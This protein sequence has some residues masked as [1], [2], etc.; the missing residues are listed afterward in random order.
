MMC[1]RNHISMGLSLFSRPNSPASPAIGGN[2]WAQPSVLAWALGP[3]WKGGSQ[4]GLGSRVRHKHPSMPSTLHGLLCMSW[5]HPLAGDSATAL[6]Y[7]QR[8]VSNKDCHQVTAQQPSSTQVIRLH[9]PL[10]EIY[11]WNISWLVDNIIWTWN[12]GFGCPTSHLSLHEP[13]CP[14]D[15]CWKEG[16]GFFP[17]PLLKWK[18][19]KK[20]DWVSRS[21]VLG[22]RHCLKESRCL[23]IR[24]QVVR[25]LAQLL[26]QRMGQTGV[27]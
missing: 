27:F 1:L 8:G 24:P 16:F 19:L 23:S 13:H 9:T 26:V 5:S 6:S 15:I 21:P 10:Q 18:Q 7:I 4:A 17:S 12:F 2:S 20:V 3:L 14:R 22:V 25:C 11:P